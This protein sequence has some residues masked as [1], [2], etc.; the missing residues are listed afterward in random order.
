ML[1]LKKRQTRNLEVRRLIASK[2]TMHSGNVFGRGCWKLSCT[3]WTHGPRW[4]VGNTANPK[5]KACG[6]V[7]GCVHTFARL[8]GLFLR[9]R[10]FGSID[11]D[12]IC[13][14]RVQAIWLVLSS[15]YIVRIAAS[16]GSN[17]FI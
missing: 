12:R 16:R 7:G 5:R 14:N 2:I 1:G 6:L 15:S 4:E 10:C 3:A 8:A 13:E 9:A 17:E 11:S